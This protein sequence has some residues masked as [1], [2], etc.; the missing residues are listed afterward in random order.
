MQVGEPVYQLLLEH[1]VVAFDLG[2]VEDLAGH[3][4]GHSVG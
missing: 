2:F 1:H 3:I 4:Q